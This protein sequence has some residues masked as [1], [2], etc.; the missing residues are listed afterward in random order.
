MWDLSKNRAWPCDQMDG[1]DLEEV[2]TATWNR[3]A[4]GIKAWL[5]SGMFGCWAG[6]H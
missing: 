3:L 2:A 5:A 4:R 6:L 1:H